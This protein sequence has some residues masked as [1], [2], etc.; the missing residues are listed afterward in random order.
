MRFLRMTP[1]LLLPLFAITGC[2]EVL[3]PSSAEDAVGTGT[4]AFRLSSVQVDSLASQADTMDVVLENGSLQRTLRVG[5]S[6]N[7]EFT[8]LPVGAWKVAVTLSRGGVAKFQGSGFVTIVAGQIVQAKISLSQATGSLVVDIGIGDAVALPARLEGIWILE[9]LP[10]LDT[11][12]VHPKIQLLSTGAALLGGLCEGTSNGNW[13]ADDSLVW[14][15]K[16]V[17]LND[18]VACK[19]SLEAGTIMDAVTGLLAKPLRWSVSDENGRL[20]LVDPATRKTLAVFYPYHAT[21]AL[22]EVQKLWG[23]WFLSSLPAIG[24]ASVT[25]TIPLVFD[26]TGELSGSDGCNH[27]SGK[28]TK[29]T[30]S[31]VQL[32]RG[33]ST[34]M[35]CLDSATQAI[36]AGIHGAI[37]G[38]VVWRVEQLYGIGAD[39]RTLYLLDTST[40]ATLATYS[41][42]KPR[43]VFPPLLPPFIIPNPY[44][45]TGVWGLVSMPIEG[46]DS[47]N[48][49][50]LVFDSTGKIS[51]YI[52]CNSVG[53]SWALDDAGQLAIN[54]FSSTFV[55]CEDSI[56]TLV[57]RGMNLLASVPLN[58]SID[59]TATGGESITLYSSLTGAKMA[60][61]A[62]ARYGVSYPT[63]PIDPILIDPIIEPIPDFE[64][65]IM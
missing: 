9:S 2:N 64:G 43:S 53:G 20:S 59:T 28:W 14:I 17:A 54:G 31:T 44:A 5:L 6:D 24:L 50:T 36:E 61:F 30:D 42:A 11:V 34:K 29:V 46:L 55:A 26:T 45:V 40:G 63:L 35:N 16:G 15:D 23:S 49:S 60:V 33:T 52:A 3:S 19:V 1:L 21:G 7:V 65:P 41:S 8:A 48:G 37:S 10:G 47:A 22:P 57:M 12:V 38:T 25:D 51:G 13:T 62:L 18:L 56:S 58:W 27:W 4:V 32:E 39:V